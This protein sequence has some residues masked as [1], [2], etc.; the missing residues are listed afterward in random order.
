MPDNQVIC[1]GE[2]LWDVLPTGKQAGGAPFNVAVHLQQ[3]GV[4]AQL[5]SRVGDDEPGREL[6]AFA[7]AKEL[8]TAQVQLDM[9]YSTGFVQANVS[10]AHEV[11]YDIVQPVAWDWIEHQAGLS[12]LVAEAGAFVYGSLAARSSVSRH[13]LHQLLLHARFRVLDVNLRPPHYT[14]SEVEHLLDAADLVKM[15]EHELKQIIEWSGQSHDLATALPW[16]A[17]HFG[18]RAVCVTLGA[19]GA[20]LWASGHLYHAAGVAVQVQD[21]IGSGDAF[22][23][24]LLSGWLAGEAPQQCLRYACAA[25]ALVASHVGATPVISP[26]G[27]RAQMSQ[28][29]G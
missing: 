11:S 13:T 24:A 27:I 8:N 2:M 17:Q 16:L 18:L 25:G 15:N 1:Y 29:G 14:R 5:I 28:A 26:A 4:E 7:A 23:A 22:L 3:L 12:S 6:L 20:V 10:D 9:H 19:K 21:T